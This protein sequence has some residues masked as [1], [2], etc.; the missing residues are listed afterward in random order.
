MIGLPNQTEED[1]VD[2]IL[3]FKEMDIDMIGMGP[4]VVHKYTIR[5]KSHKKKE[6]IQRLINTLDLFMD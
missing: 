2:D 3:F 6:K 4:Y 1:M 5:S